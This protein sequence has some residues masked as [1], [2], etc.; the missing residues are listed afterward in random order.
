M[1][2]KFTVGNTPY[3]INIGYYFA[4]EELPSKFN[5]HIL[6]LLANDDNTNDTLKTLL[7]NDTLVISLMWH[8]M[9]E[10]GSV[11]NTGDDYT[12]FLKKLSSKE[13][14]DFREAFWAEV[15]NFSGPWKR[16]ALI[17]AW[18]EGKKYLKN[19]TSEQLLSDLG[20]EELKPET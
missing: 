6:D 14:A 15:T 1:P 13:V 11:N 19:L 7:F 18:K 17:T 16:E 4:M 2:T 20:Q 8:Y 10:D 3:T 12:D 9:L 5:I